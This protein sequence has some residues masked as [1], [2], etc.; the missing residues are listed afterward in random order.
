[1]IFGI[2]DLYV[3]LKRSAKEKIAW[4]DHTGMHCTLYSFPVPRI[5]R[6]TVKVTL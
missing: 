5:S 6:T 4:N 3:P 1:M 2:R